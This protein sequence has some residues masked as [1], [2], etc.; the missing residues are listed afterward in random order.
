AGTATA[1][2]DSGVSS[3]GQAGAEPVEAAREL[4][5]QQEAD[6]GPVPAEERPLRNEGRSDRTERGERPQRGEGRDGKGE[7]RGRDRDRERD[8]NKDRVAANSIN[9]AKL[10]A[11]SM[12]ELNQMAKDLGVENFGTMRKHEVIFHILQ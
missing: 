8:G 9:I 2:A 12:S 1:V 6:S 11:M 4:A 5:Q 7:N 3:E 10:Q